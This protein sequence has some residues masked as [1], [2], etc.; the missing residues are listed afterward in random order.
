MI[1]QS[2]GSFWAFTASAASGARLRK[3]VKPVSSSI[4]AIDRAH[5]LSDEGF[6]RSL[7]NQNPMPISSS[8][9]HSATD[10]PVLPRR[11]RYSTVQQF[12]GSPLR[13]AR[14][15]VVVRPSPKKVPVTT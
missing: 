10:L 5:C 4:W 7:A 13:L 9:E 14:L 3:N 6:E 12:E 11:V 15:S 2:A 8:A 1:F